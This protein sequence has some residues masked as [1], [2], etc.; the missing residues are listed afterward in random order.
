M[1]AKQ[2]VKRAAEEKTIIPAFNIPY[3]PMME[4][5]VRAIVDEDSIAMIQT[6]RLEWVKFEAHSPEAVAGEYFKYYN[7]EYTLLHLD[8]VPEIDEDGVQ[9]D[10]LPIMERALAAG[11][12]S[13]MIDASRLSLEENI[14][15]TLRVAELVQKSGDVA[16]EA[17]L[18]AVAGHESGGLG[19][20][21]EELFQTRKGFTD[22]GEAK[23][24]AA[25]S[26]CDWLSVAAGNIH[27]AVAESTRMD[28][29]PEA[30][31]DTGHIAAL[32]DAAG[33]MPLVLHGGS[34]INRENL[35]AAIENGIA[36][37]NVGTEI[38]QPY[39]AALEKRPKDIAYAQE[40][41]YD[42]TRWVIREFV[43]TSG[44]RAKL[45]GPA[46]TGGER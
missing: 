2:V 18:G 8:H 29:K 35:L 38:R 19:M 40:Q 14:K 42:R 17:E 5:V 6:A 41:V 24:F 1:T 22:I 21:Y 9:V 45:F 12:Q 13:V 36:K 23:R 30:R 20:S 27:G 39:V 11:Y 44:N 26:G 15:A 3:L 7:P 32:R 33:G 46:K 34:G 25:E 4:P 43:R 10:V 28:K 16:L 37:I 31:L